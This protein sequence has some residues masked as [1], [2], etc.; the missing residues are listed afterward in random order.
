MDWGDLFE[1]V[2]KL[3]GTL[4]TY[5]IRAIKWALPWVKRGIML[6]WPLWLIGAALGIGNGIS[7]A[8]ASGVKSWKSEQ[9]ETITYTVTIHWSENDTSEIRVRADTDYT[10]NGI[11]NATDEPYALDYVVYLDDFS[12]KMSDGKPTRWFSPINLSDNSN[13]NWG[14]FLGLYNSPYGGAQYVNGG[15][16]A[17]RSITED[18]ELWAVWQPDSMP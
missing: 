1:G 10:I 3:I 16:Y 8:M 7:G 15:G 2:F 9:L 17:V 6:M 14:A 13:R 4:I 18:T 5:L 11:V 12:G